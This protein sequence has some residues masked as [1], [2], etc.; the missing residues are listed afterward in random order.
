MS[1]IRVHSSIKMKKIVKIIKLIPRIILNLWLIFYDW[2]RE[3]IARRK[4]WSIIVGS[5]LL[6]LILAGGGIWGWMKYK[7]NKDPQNQPQVY[8]AMVMVVDQKNSDPEEDKRASLKKGDVIAYFPEGHSW[9]ETERI[10]YLIV[11]IKLKPDEATK[12]TEAETKE[13]KGDKGDVKGE[14]GEKGVKGEMG[15]PR[16]ETIRARKY[17]LDLPGYDLQKFWQSHEQPFQDKVFGAGI[18]DKK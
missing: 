12:L 18:I 15:G 10:S 17:T 11:K 1:I 5:V 14:K 8:E 2:V 13:V 16:M 6:L 4:K 7:N 9:S 3:K